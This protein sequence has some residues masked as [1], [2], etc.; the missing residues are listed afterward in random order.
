M[1]PS[2]RREL[3]YQAYDVAR[4][5]VQVHAS[6]YLARKWL[7]L[8]TAK[9]VEYMGINEKAKSAFEMKVNEK[10]KMQS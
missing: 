5:T 3:E 6:E 1:N 8:T 9:C 4:A 10:N 7:A 2:I